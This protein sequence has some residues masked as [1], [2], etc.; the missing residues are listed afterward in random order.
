MAAC[1]LGEEQKRIWISTISEMMN[2]GPRMILRLPKIRQ[3][4]VAHPEPFRWYSRRRMELEMLELKRHNRFLL[5][6]DKNY[7]VDETDVMLQAITKRMDDI[8]TEVRERM[9]MEG[10]PVNSHQYVFDRILM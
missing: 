8:V 1:G 4:L 7:V 5:C 10:S 3:V 6:M 2:E 9:I